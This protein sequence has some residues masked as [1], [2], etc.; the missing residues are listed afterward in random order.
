[1]HPS[2][3]SFAVKLTAFFGYFFLLLKK[4]D[5]MSGHPP[6]TLNLKLQKKT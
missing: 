4:S 5:W 6:T 1:M 2:W 3:L